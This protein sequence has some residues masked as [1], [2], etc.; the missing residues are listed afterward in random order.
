M[1]AYL[2]EDRNGA[3]AKHP[4]ARAAV[5]TNLRQDGCCRRTIAEQ[6]QLAEEAS[7]TRS[8]LTQELQGPAVLR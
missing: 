6:V 8:Q 1:Q 3:D 7:R 2:K 4:T 5:S